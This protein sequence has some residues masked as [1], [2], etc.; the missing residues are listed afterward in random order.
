M[1]TAEQLLVILLSSALAVFLMLAIVATIKVIK[2]LNHIDG[3]VEKAEKIAH[4]AEAVGNMIKKTAGPMALGRLVANMADAVFGST[5]SSDKK[6][7]K[8]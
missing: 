2:I 6:R 4:N 5:R 3:I 8:S 7:G 1:N